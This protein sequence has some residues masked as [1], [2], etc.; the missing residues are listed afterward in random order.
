MPALVIDSS[1]AMAWCFDDEA[2]DG[3]WRV[4]DR[5]EEETAVVPSLWHLEIANV[6][7]LA[8]RKRRI[9]AAKVAEFVDLIDTLPIEVD[10]ETQGRAL[11]QTLELS[12]AQHLTAYDAAYLELAMRAGLPLATTDRELRRA[13]AKLGVSLLGT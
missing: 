6:L 4:L 5:L 7:A 12:R 8:E 11:A 10:P 2:T 13:A 1:V 3:T 9:T